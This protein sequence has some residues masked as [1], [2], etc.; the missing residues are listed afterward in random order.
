MLICWGSLKVFL[1]KNYDVSVMSTTPQNVLAITETNLSAVSCDGIFSDLNSFVARRKED[2]IV[3]DLSRLG[4]VD[5]YGM[6]ALC[7]VGRWLSNKYW[8]ITCR[9]PE[10]PEIE[11]YLTRMGVFE[12]L[13]AYVTPD[14]E[15]KMGRPAVKNESLLEV[16]EIIAR[17]DIESVL[18]LIESRVGSILTEE[19]GYTVREITGFKNV[20][21]ELCHNILD[22]SGDRGYLVAQRYS[23]PKLK[24]KFAIIGVCDLG[25]GI[26]KSLA[27]RFDVSSWTHAQAIGNAIRKEFSREPTRGLGLY[28]VRQ[29]CQAYKGS[30][31]IRSGDSRVY[32]RGKRTYVHPSVPF[33]GTQVSI[34][35][36]EKEL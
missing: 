28:I 12:A 25:I 2:D 5:P 22:H 35:L 9:L 19:L 8:D 16:L 14:R 1:K 6:G 13:E 3:L 24:K 10:D 26:R 29:I 20:V 18:S 4:F 27:S 21:A 32:L 31:H 36:Y 11:S 30:I 34:T 7:L 17:E 15:P 23:N 33:P